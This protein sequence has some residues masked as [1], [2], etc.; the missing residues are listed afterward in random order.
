MGL[1]GSLDWYTH[2]YTKDNSAFVLW[3]SK[4]KRT[5]LAAKKHATQVQILAAPFIVY[6]E[7]NGKNKK[8]KIIRKVWKQIWEEC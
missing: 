1:W 4:S 6:S 3:V 2:K 7:K 8:S 5:G